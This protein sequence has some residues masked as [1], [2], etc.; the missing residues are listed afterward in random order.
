MRG[1]NFALFSAHAP[2]QSA[3]AKN[4]NLIDRDYPDPVT[5][6]LECGEFIATL[7]EQFLCRAALPFYRNGGT[8]GRIGIVP[9]LNSSQC[10]EPC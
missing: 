4:R 8:P 6:P 10:Q 1:I 3:L 7:Q 9:R 2:S 5:E